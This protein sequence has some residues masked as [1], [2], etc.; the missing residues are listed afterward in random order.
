M[1][2]PS[3]PPPDLLVPRGRLAE[4]PDAGAICPQ[5]SHGG[6][7]LTSPKERETLEPTWL[8]STPT[9]ELIGGPQKN[10]AITTHTICLDISLNADLQY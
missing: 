10:A 1:L 3:F 5:Q 2:A 6:R 8:L 4:T 9:M 7:L